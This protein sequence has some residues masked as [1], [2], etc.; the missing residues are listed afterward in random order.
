MR[1][2]N[3]LTVFDDNPNRPV[4]CGDMLLLASA[5]VQHAYKSTL[6]VG[7]ALC[8]DLQ[9]W[10]ISQSPLL[11]YRF[12]DRLISRGHLT[13]IHLKLDLVCYAPSLYAAGSPLET[14]TAVRF[15][16]AEISC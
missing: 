12:D 14:P 1:L 8:D 3:R 10:L 5:L 4:L 16:R 15:Q 6:G 11:S 7:K 9:A 2:R 13:S